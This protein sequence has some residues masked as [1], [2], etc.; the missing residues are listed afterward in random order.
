MTFGQNIGDSQYAVLMNKVTF[1]YL[2][3][4]KPAIQNIDLRIKKGEIVLVTGPA[5]AGKTTLCCCMNGL[6]PHFYEGKLDGEVLVY[7]LNTKM[8]SISDLS[9]FAGLL[10][11]DPSTQ[12]VLPTVRDEIAFGPEN[13]GVPP[14]EIERRV[15][16][17]AR[18][19]RLEKYLNQNPHFLSGGEKQAC[20]LAS[21]MAMNPNMYVLDEPT[22]NLDPLGS[23]QILQVIMG[24]VRKENKTMII[25]EHRIEELAPLVDRMLVM[26]EGRI[27]LDGK[28]REVLE[29][30][31]SMAEIGIKIPQVTLLAQKLKKIG[32]KFDSLPITLEEASEWLSHVLRA[33]AK[34]NFSME[35]RISS[36]TTG[37]RNPVIKVKDLW[38]VYPGG[39]HA[40]RGV[41][42][43]VYEGDFIALLGQNG[44]GK[45]TLVKH[46][47]G[48]LKPTKGKVL[49]N[50]IDVEKAKVNELAMKVGYCFQNPDNQIFSRTVRDEVAFGLKNLGLPHSSIKKLVINA[51]EMVGLKH[52]IDEDPFSLS[53]GERQRIAFASVIAMEPDILVVDEPTTGQDYVRSIEMMNLI[54]KFHERNKAVIVI[55]HDMNLAAEYAKRVVILQNGQVIFDGPTRRAFSQPEMLATTFLKPPQITLLGQ[56]LSSLS[57]PNDIL[58]IDEAYNFLTQFLE[59]EKL[60]N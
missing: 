31:E 14:D 24:L 21:I 25:V 30:A 60:G 40:L 48:L 49:V 22:S 1:T 13:Y 29:N 9:M 54:S 19:T 44:S 53:L 41:N 32:I 15:E 26:N 12:L 20:A 5:G 33:K 38:H 10:F 57:L 58:T 7:G 43:E 28:P 47:N 6:I 50:G 59:D 46:F 34:I 42:L 18:F 16:E 23:Y 39:I 37:T 45:T 2:G 17:C 52:V 55:T 51:L 36:N 3:G 8:Y 4:R 35:R 11:Q 27:I 56:R